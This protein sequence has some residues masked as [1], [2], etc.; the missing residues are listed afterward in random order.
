MK[1]RSTIRLHP[2][3]YHS[4]I[5]ISK[6]KGVSY[7]SLVNVALTRFVTAE[8][9]KKVI[10]ERV[11]KTDLKKFLAVLAKAD[12]HPSLPEEDDRLPE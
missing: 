12:G 9:A 5:R 11:K 4:L 6:Q 7:N 8:D 1:Q 3:L 10:S 2:D